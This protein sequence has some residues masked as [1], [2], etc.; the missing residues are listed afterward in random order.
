MEDFDGK[1][2]DWNAAALKMKRLDK[3]FIGINEVNGN[4]LAFNQEYGVYNYE[5]KFR[6]CDNQFLEVDSK[7]KNEERQRGE[8]LRNKILIL[9]DRYPVH[10]TLVNKYTGKRAIKVNRQIAN[11][12]LHLLFEYE[13]MVRKFIDDHGMDTSYDNESALF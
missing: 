8:E 12:L 9:L 7:L 6:K 2:S 10:K 4:L 3:E 11:L 13:R 1:I 5:L